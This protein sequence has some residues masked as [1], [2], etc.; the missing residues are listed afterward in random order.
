MGTAPITARSDE[1]IDD[2]RLATRNAAVLWTALAEARG[3]ALTRLPGLLA[4]HGD[5]RAGL[6]ILLLTSSPSAADVAALTDLVR[7]RLPGRVVVEDPFGGVDL[8]GA[9]LTRRSLPIMVRRPAPVPPPAL[10]V[11]LATTPAQ[12][13][14]AE[15]LVVHGFPLEAWRPHRPGE[16]FPPAL[17]DRPQTRFLLAHRGGTPAGACL[18][19]ADDGAGIYWMTTLPTHRSR[20]VGR[21]LLHGALAHLGDRPVTLTAARAGRPLYDSLGFAPVA[22]ATWW[23]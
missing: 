9:G 21:A 13:A 7:R 17:L 22:D 2:L 19:V 1:A 20:G 10:E 14:V 15:G 12:L 23:S 16:A 5:D 3:H 11:T 4:V 8:T 18:T 6:R